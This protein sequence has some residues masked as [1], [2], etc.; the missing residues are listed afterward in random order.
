MIKKVLVTD[1]E[2]IVRD[3]LLEVLKK[4]EFDAIGA[5]NGKEAL[6]L[7][8]ENSF[9][10]VIVD[11]KMP[12]MTG[13]DLLKKIKEMA[14]STIVIIITAYGS[15][16]N[17]VEA[18]KLGAFHYLVKPFSPSAF[19][20]ILEKAKEH[21]LLV[22]ENQYLRE[23][24][25]GNDRQGRHAIAES[26]EMKKILSDALRIAQSNASVFISG[27][28]GTGKEVVAQMIHAHSLRANKPFIKINCAAVPETL[29]ESEFFGHEKGAFTGAIQRKLGRFE[30]ADGG[31]LLLDE[32]SEIP[33]SVQAKLLRAIQEREFER[34]GGA[35]PIP[36]KVDIRFISTSNRDVEKMIADHVLREDLF[37]RLNVI[38]ILLPPLRERKEDILPLTEYFIQKACQENHKDRKT[39]SAQAKKKL[40][41][42]S[43]PGNVR[44]LANTIER[45]VVMNT[46]LEINESDLFLT[47]STHHQNITLKDLEKK[48]IIETLQM[49]QNNKKKAAEV[50]GIS[51]K[52]LGNKLKQYHL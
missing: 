25:F 12:D 37:Y 3:F 16:E 44:E 8:K 36:I 52:M 11:M 48:H 6:K 38:P 26:P 4:N 51:Q 45:S 17:A 33:L 18:I 10:A 50:L 21:R 49:Y 5:P 43:W 1:D 31:T 41:E 20:A 9:D 28:S 39:L 27:E 34:I 2:E 46:G 14:P 22:E 13:I 24:S 29:I 23:Q 42:Y 7:M 30:L 40:K 47:E 15:V 35:K 32:I 19:L